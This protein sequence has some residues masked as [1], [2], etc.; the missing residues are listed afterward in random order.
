MVLPQV[1]E[2]ARNHF[3]YGAD[4]IRELLLAHAR[5]ENSARFLPRRG[6]FEEM[7]RDALLHSGERGVRELIPEGQD[8]ARQLLDDSPRDVG[9]APRERAQRLH[10]HDQARRIRERLGV[11][12]TGTARY[13]DDAHH[14]PRPGVA[15]RDLTALRRLEVHAEKSGDDQRR[16]WIRG[17]AISEG[18]G[19]DVFRRRALEQ[20][21]ERGARK[22]R[23]EAP[24]E[25]VANPE[26]VDAPSLP[27]TG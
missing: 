9:V 14:I 26:I 19:F 27:T 24:G 23:E 18:A 4:E 5:Y 2:R 11:H 22:S 6:Q 13:A 16:A 21:I 20:L 15:D 8:R 3:A 10:V 7:P 12:R 25:R 1:P 17:G